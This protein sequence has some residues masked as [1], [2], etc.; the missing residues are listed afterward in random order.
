M[1]CKTTKIVIVQS[2]QGGKALDLLAAHLRVPSSD[3]SVC[4]PSQT[5]SLSIFKLVC[6]Q[7]IELLKFSANT[8][9]WTVVRNDQP[10]ETQIEDGAVLAVSRR[11][12]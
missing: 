6:L 1:P 11:T 4:H 5:L 10:L 7:P 8:N 3:A 9:E 2:V 12:V